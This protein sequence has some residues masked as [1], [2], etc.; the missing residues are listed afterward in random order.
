[1]GFFFTSVIHYRLFNAISQE[2]DLQVNSYKTSLK[3]GALVTIAVLLVFGGVWIYIYLQL[4]ESASYINAF[5][6]LIPFN[7][8]T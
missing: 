8:L 1:M 5:L 6:L 4:A 2:M 3:I 7:I